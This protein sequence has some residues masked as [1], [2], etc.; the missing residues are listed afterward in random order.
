MK[1]KRKNQYEITEAVEYFLRDAGIHGQYLMQKVLAEWPEIVGEVIGAQTDDVW[2]VDGVLHVRMK[3][4]AW[5]QEVFMQ[6]SEIITRIHAHAGEE[7]V[8]EIKVDALS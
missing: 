1:K 7:I 5:R 8:R 2:Y 3:T 6:R 4:Q